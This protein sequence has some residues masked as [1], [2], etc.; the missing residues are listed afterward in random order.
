MTEKLYYM[1]MR[2]KKVFC[3][4]DGVI[5]D[6][7]SEPNCVERFD[8]EKGFFRALKPIKDNLIAIKLLISY[9]ADVNILTASPNEQADKDKMEWLQ[10]YLPELSK[11]KIIMCRNTDVKA[12]MVGDLEG[13]LLIDDYTQNLIDWQ[14]EGGLALKYVGL[15]DDRIGRHTLYGMEYVLN[16][17]E[18]TA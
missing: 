18:L 10:Y 6:F 17:M 12:H 14:Q 4:M 7:N 5:A 16:L 11:E 13:A 2:V 9:G 8:K 3:D 15:G 1:L